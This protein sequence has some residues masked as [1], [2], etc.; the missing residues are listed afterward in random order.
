MFVDGTSGMSDAL[1]TLTSPPSQPPSGDCFMFYYNLF[2]STHDQLVPF[3]LFIFCFQKNGG[4]KYLRVRTKEDNGEFNT[5]WELSSEFSENVWAIGQVNISGQN[6][7]IEAEKNTEHAGYA[8][9]DEF[10]IIPGLDKC[11]VL[12]PIANVNNP[13]PSPSTTKPPNGK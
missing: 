8:A 7:V 11:D 4:I 1:V 13:T 6:I 12:P 9:V 2:V 5:I 10:L 3:L